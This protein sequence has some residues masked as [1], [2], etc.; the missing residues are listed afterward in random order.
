MTNDSLTVKEKKA[1]DIHLAGSHLVK[2]LV[3]PETVTVLTLNPR[4]NKEP[5]A[6]GS[7]AFWD[8]GAIPAPSISQHHNESKELI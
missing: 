5:R 4:R 7:V 1:L 2:S 3:T 6:A 8:K